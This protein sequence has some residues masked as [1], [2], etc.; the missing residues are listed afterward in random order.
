[1]PSYVLRDLHRK[2][3]GYEFRLYGVVT[4]RTVFMTGGE[5]GLCAIL[6]KVTSEGGLE[7]PS[8]VL[9]PPGDGAVRWTASDSSV[10]KLPCCVDAA[11]ADKVRWLKMFENRLNDD[12]VIGDHTMLA[13]LENDVKALTKIEQN[14]P[15][16]RREEM[17]PPFCS[18]FG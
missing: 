18:L 6:V 12:V 4:T 15:P 9:A 16:I 7:S 11:R 14:P 2:L 3:R 5:M 17:G 13:G 8:S 1:M 10:W